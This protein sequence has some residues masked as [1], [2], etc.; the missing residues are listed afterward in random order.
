MQS[1]QYIYL[2]QEREFIRLNENVYKIGK[3]TQ[4]N[5]KRLNQY[6]KGS[7]L[8][9]QSI[10][11]D[12]HIIEKELIKI[13]KNQ[14]KQHKE[15]GNEYFEGD[16]K[17]MINYIN[18]IIENENKYILSYTSSNESVDNVSDKSSSD[19]EEENII[20]FD[21]ENNYTINTYKEWIKTNDIVNIIITKKNGEG[22]IKFK[23]C[24]W[25]KLFNISFDNE[26]YETLK[27][28][29]KHTIDSSSIYY[30]WVNPSD[31]SYND[32][33]SLKEM[34]NLQYTYKHKE[35]NDI[36][37]Y[38]EFHMSNNQYNYIEIKNKEYIFLNILYDN[39][40]IYNDII[41]S[42][43]TTEYEYYKLKYHEYVFH[44]SDNIKIF[45]SLNNEFVPIDN[46][47]NNYIL[48]EESIISSRVI[49]ISNVI[50]INIVDNI[51]DSL[52]ENNIKIKFKNLVYNILVKNDSI[53]HFYDYNECLLT[54]W[55]TC[56]F[57]SLYFNN[58]EYYENRQ[59]IKD[60]IK[61]NTYIPRFVIIDNYKNKS[62]EL[63][64]ND[65]SK[66]GIKIFI[67][68]QTNKQQKMYNINTFKKFL[69][70]NIDNLTSI[71][72]IE[73]NTNHVSIKQI[74]QYDD[75]IFTHPHLFFT[76]FLKWCS[77]NI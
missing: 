28:W 63:Q 17:Q 71:I 27:G 22:F 40:K 9:L 31:S 43:Y 73:H 44:T 24:L 52:I 50:N 12:C 35:T 45:N 37:T 59:N 10:C 68:K 36:I 66:L 75:S 76:N 26:L 72:N 57:N 1:S 48:L 77:S 4:S 18:T 2:L 60:T 6:P 15:Y 55:I 39:E 42:C 70:D 67:I 65:F 47:I 14:F 11:S 51:L 34:F 23:N 20:I 30:K 69:N 21:Q 53:I 74:I 61:N 29:I 38:D 25:K 32:I 5:N 54:T 19:N 49:T 41:K 8:L 16:Y 13:F 62:I 58:N 64:I 7:A 33:I 56:W 3:T 46:C